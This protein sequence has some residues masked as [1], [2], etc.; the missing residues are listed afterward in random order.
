[1]WR[2]PSSDGVRGARHGLT[3]DHRGSASLQLPVDLARVVAGRERGGLPRP[4]REQLAVVAPRGLGAEHPGEP[5][6]GGKRRDEAARLDR[7]HGT[8]RDAA[9]QSPAHRPCQHGAGVDRRRDRLPVRVRHDR[10]TGAK[11]RRAHLDPRR[12]QRERRRDPAPVCDPA[13]G[14]HRCINGIHHLRHQRERADERPLG[15]IRGTTPDARPP[16]HR[17]RRWR[18]RRPRPEPRASATVVAVPMTRMPRSCAPSIT[19]AGGTP[20][21]TLSTAGAAA[22]TASS[23]SSIGGRKAAGGGRHRTP[24]ASYS[25]AR[26]SRYGPRSTSAGRHLVP[27]RQPEVHGERLAP[28]GREGR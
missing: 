16:R 28:S 21:T 7:A 18:R 1:M 23:C 22:I 8:V 11:E 2:P 24:A 15:S 19:S 13:R 4:Q 3:R 6:L 26:A 5:V 14:D 27:G 25:G 12:P 9:G 20:N 10:L 17:S